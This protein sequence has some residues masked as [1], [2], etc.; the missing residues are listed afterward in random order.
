MSALKKKITSHSIS[1]F[2]EKNLLVFFF[3]YNHINTQE[4]RVIKNQLSK[5]KKVKKIVVKNQ[6][7]NNVIKEKGKCD[8]NKTQPFEKLKP[9]FQGP[10]FLI[11]MSSP[12]ECEILFNVIK[13][14]KKLIFVGGLYQGQYIN[15]LHLSSILKGE[16]QV[17]TDLINIFQS[18]LYTCVISTYFL[19]LYSLLKSYSFQNSGKKDFSC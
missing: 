3:N 14:H 15:H 11:G 9:L 18:S 19:P 10:T 13:K 4:W 1:K 8:H 5:I 7:A 12:Q 17:Y 6:I 2:L 16:K